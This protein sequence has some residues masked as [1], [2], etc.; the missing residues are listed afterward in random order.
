MSA[1]PNPP[2]SNLVGENLCRNVVALNLNYLTRAV[3]VR[4]QCVALPA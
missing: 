2:S 3:A 1:W 4:L